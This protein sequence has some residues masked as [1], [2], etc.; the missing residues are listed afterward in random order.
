LFFVP[1]KDLFEIIPLFTPRRKLVPP[2]LPTI[3]V[4]IAPILKIAMIRIFKLININ[5]QESTKKGQ[6]DKPDAL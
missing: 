1:P 5:F 6:R 4:T 3:S 2:I